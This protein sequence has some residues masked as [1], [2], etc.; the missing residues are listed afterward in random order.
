VLRSLQSNFVPAAGL[1]DNVRSEKTWNA[2]TGVAGIDYD[3]GPQTLAYGK[4]SRG[5]KAGGFN[6][7]ECTNSFNPETLWAYEAGSKSTFWDGQARVNLAGFYYKFNDIQFT[8]YLN[9]AS[10][11]RNAAN[12]TLYGVELEHTFVPRVLRGVQLDGSASYIHSAYGNQLLQDPLGLA[13]LNIKGNQLI[14]A[15]K[16]KLNLGAQYSANLPHGDAL[17]LRAEGS[18]TSTIYNDVFNGKAPFQAGTTQPPYWVANARL[19]WES[20]DT[21]FAGQLFVE[22]IGNE[23]YSYSRVASATGAYLSGQFSPPRTYGARFAMK[24]G[25]AR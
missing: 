9:N 23:L 21:R 25:S 22:N 18:Y 3:L 13:T 4:V 8:T 16:W 6:P 17:T 1:C 24:F 2:V 20:P 5:Y 14:R 10:T 12:A 19:I 15:P 11:I 7:A